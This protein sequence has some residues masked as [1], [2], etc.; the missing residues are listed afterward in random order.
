MLPRTIT[1][2]QPVEELLILCE[3]VNLEAFVSMRNTGLVT[4]T[5]I[6]GLGTLSS[7]ETCGGGC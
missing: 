4:E 5:R 2:G 6:P 3:Y 7:I 1:G